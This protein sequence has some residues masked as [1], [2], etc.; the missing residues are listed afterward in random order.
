[1]AQ[2]KLVSWSGAAPETRNITVTTT[3]LVD[4]DLVMMSSGKAIVYADGASVQL[5]GIY[6]VADTGTTFSGLIP[7]P[8]LNL[9][10][11]GVF[12]GDG[13]TDAAPTAPDVIAP[14]EILNGTCEIEIALKANQTFGVGT[15]VGFSGGT[16]AWVADTGATAKLHLVK[17]VLIAP[18]SAANGLGIVALAAAGLNPGA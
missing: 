7:T 16:G 17:E 14:V 5:A 11:T 8:G 9:T 3:G 2:P 13:Y 4:G 15:P 6:H 12:G 10:G 18:T 1:M